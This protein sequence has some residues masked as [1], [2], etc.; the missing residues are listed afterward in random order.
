MNKLRAWVIAVVTGLA[1]SSAAHASPE[2]ARQDQWVFRERLGDDSK[3]P[4]AAFMSWNYSALLFRATCDT[5]RRELILDYFGDGEVRLRSG[6]VL[7]LGRAGGW[8]K[9]AT[10]LVEGRLEGRTAITPKLIRVLS[11][12]QELDIAAPNAM[13]EAWHVGTTTTLARLVHECR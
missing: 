7:S 10:K 12:P 9:L 11:S 5:A 13:D 4:V 3:G 6:Q 2:G 1:A 8:V